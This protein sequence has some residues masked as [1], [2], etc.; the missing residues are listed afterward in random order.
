MKA[1]KKIAPE[2][3]ILAAL[4]P[5][6]RF[7]AAFNLAREAFKDSSLTLDDIEAAVKKVR[8]RAYAERQRKNP[9]GR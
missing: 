7:E 2:D 9:S 4:S 1:P 5:R 3:Y 8:K 6:E